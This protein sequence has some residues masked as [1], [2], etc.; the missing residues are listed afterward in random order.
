MY[1]LCFKT[2]SYLHIW[3]S[4]NQHYANRVMPKSILTFK[5][6][7]QD[8]ASPLLCMY[9]VNYACFD[10]A[11]IINRK[12]AKRNQYLIHAHYKEKNSC[13]HTCRSH[14]SG[15]WVMHVH[16][17]VKKGF[18]TMKH[19]CKLVSKCV[20]VEESMSTCVKNGEIHHLSCQNN[21]MDT[22]IK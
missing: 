13:L 18:L 3:D 21:R 20:Y 10:K 15:I 22:S 17:Y 6:I 16:M 8:H 4:S 19:S 5:K 1:I 2:I 14:T 9:P 7:V 12:H 11:C